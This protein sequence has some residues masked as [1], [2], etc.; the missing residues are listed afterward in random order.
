MSGHTPGPWTVRYQNC[1]DEGAAPA[2]V[3]YIETAHTGNTF[4]REIAV[5]YGDEDRDQNAN[6]IIAAPD[7]LL[8]LKAVLLLRD[9]MSQLVHVDDR[10]CEIA[11]AAIA[12]AE[13]RQP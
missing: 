5:L 2:I 7:L 4:Q 13:G 10:L 9:A 11:L 6:V 8:A 12:K 3:G 1:A